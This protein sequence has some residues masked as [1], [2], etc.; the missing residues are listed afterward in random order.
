[1][2]DRPRLLIEDWLPVRELGIESRRGRAV[3]TLPPTNW[4]HVWWAR[5]PL[6]A[7]AGVVLAGL[8]P[9]WSPELVATFPG[10]GQLRSEY[11]YHSWLLHLIGIWGDPIAARAEIDQALTLSEGSSSRAILIAS[12][13]AYRQFA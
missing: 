1:M 12:K 2:T 4:L 5:R 6:V 13:Q 3:T 10:A 9:A 11:A 7:S 8:L